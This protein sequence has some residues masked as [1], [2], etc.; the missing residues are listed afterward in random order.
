MKLV[1]IKEYL[2]ENEAFL[3]NPECQELVEMTVEFYEKVGYLPPWICYFVEENGNI[4][5]SAGIKGKPIN[6]AI[7]IA[8]GTMEKYQHRGVGT[9]ICKM[10]VNLSLN[11]DPSVQITARTLPENKFS[12]RILEKNNFTC[13]G[14]V[15]D[16]DDGNVLEWVYNYQG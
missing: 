16:P 3:R 10:L 4:I 12:C 1:P 11:T 2:S 8:Y 13:V 15:D 14:I 6:G 7:E 5:G 9:N